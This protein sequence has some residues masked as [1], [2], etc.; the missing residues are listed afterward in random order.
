VG[1]IAGRPDL[2][3]VMVALWTLV[4]F[5][6]HGVRLVQAFALRRRGGAI[7]P[8]DEGMRRALAPKLAAVARVEASA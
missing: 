6:F 3:I 4:S 7:E 2:G 8:W 1:T 5:T